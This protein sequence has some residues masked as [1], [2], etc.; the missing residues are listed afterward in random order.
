MRA[1]HGG[2]NLG[3]NRD[4][5]LMTATRGIATLKPRLM[6]LQRRRFPFTFHAGL[7]MLYPS[8]EPYPVSGQKWTSTSSVAAAEM[9]IG[10][11]VEAADP[12]RLGESD[13]RWIHPPHRCNVGD[14]CEQE[15][16]TE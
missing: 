16:R 14:S 12:P 7:N 1:I 4:T 13:Y 6:L 9:H 10:S 8:T 5:A 2:P 11:W 15:S 3:A